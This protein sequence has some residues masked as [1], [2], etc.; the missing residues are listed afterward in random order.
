MAFQHA[1]IAIGFAVFFDGMDGAIARL[2][3]TTSDFGTRAGFARRRGH[4]RRCPGNA[5]LDVGLPPASAVLDPDLRGKLI[6][7][8]AIASFSFSPPAP[9]GWRASI[10][11]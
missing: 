5:G 3:H 10:S 11:R 2:T 1:A 6:Q 4:L 7:F 8:G 9:A